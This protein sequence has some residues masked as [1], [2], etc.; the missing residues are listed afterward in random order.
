MKPLTQYNFIKD[1]CSSYQQ[2]I[3]DIIVNTANP[4][5]IYLLGTSYCDKRSESIFQHSNSTSQCITE[6]FILIILEDYANKE[7]C[8]W[9]DKIEANCKEL[10]PVT[11][12]VLQKDTFTKW[13]N[14]GHPF[15]TSVQQSAE[16]I[17]NVKNYSFPDLHMVNHGTDTNNIKKNLLEGLTKAKEFL[18]GSELYQIR[19]QHGMAA[20]MLHQSV[21]QVLRN[22]LKAGTGFHISTH[23]IERLLRYAFWINRKIYE[24]FPLNNESEKRL[25]S[26]LQ[27]AYI[28]SR[29]TENYTVSFYDLHTITEK[30]RM[31]LLIFEE[32]SKKV[33]TLKESSK[34]VH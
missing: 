26:L 16:V 9:Q 17:Y 28:D 12:I 32:W 30:V 1:Q 34:A 25:F 3:V 15:A 23:N 29:Y 6:Y 5:I 13:L 22:L 20:F 7:I 31:M 18:V 11:T 14:E 27:R 19:K 8:E 33:I 24:I 4:A 2:R 10:L 21:E